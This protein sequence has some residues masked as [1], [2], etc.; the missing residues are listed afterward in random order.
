MKTAIS[1]IGYLLVALGIMAMAGSAGDCDGKCVE[2]A[3]TIMEMLTFAG[4]GLAMFLFGF[5][6]ILQKN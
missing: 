6:L 3:N 5:M 2:N 4:I 1:I